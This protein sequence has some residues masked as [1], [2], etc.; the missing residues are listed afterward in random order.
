MEVVFITSD[1]NVK[2]FE[3]HHRA[4]GGVLALSFSE[5]ET[6]D[7][8]KKHCGI[9]A[10][11]E[12]MRIGTSGRRSGVPALAVLSQDGTLVHHLNAESEGVRCL[13]GWDPAS[14]EPWNFPPSP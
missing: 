11:V 1:R 7:E 10:G 3:A 12:S 14:C 13:K 9:W 2:D 5:H 8:L 4:M 6:A